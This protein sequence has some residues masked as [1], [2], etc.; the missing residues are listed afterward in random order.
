[1]REYLWLYQGKTIP[2]TEQAITTALEER[3][4]RAACPWNDA[5]SRA[6]T[7]EEVLLDERIT[8][9]GILLEAELL[10]EAGGRNTRLPAK[11]EYE[12]ALRVAEKEELVQI[13]FAAFGE[14]EFWGRSRNG[15]R[16]NEENLC[17]GNVRGSG[18]AI[19][20]D[21]DARMPKAIWKDFCVDAYI[22]GRYSEFL[23]ER[24]LFE[25]VLE[26]VLEEGLT[27][28]S[29]GTA[30]QFLEDMIAHREQYFYYFDATQP[31]LV[32]RGASC[33][34]NILNIFAEKLAEALEKL[35][36]RIEFYDTEAEDVQGLAR[37]LGKRYKASVGFQ[38]WILSA[39]LKG[40]K[41][42]LMNR[43]GG[44]K[45][46]FIFDHP[47]WMQEQLRHVPERY[48]VLTHDRNYTAF[49]R[50]YDTGVKGAYLLPPGGREPEGAEGRAE[51]RVRRIYDVAFLGTYGNY[52]EKLAVIADCVPEVKFLAARFLLYMKQ[53]P[54]STAEDAFQRA[55][56][57][58]KIRLSQE[59]FLELFGDLKAVIQCIMYYYREKAVEQIL[60]AGIELHVFGDSW[61][62]S[63][64]AGN[65][66]MKMHE[67]VYGEDA[68]RVL[69]QSKISLNI[70]AWHKD[71]FT[72]R[73]AESMLAGAVV[74]SDYSTQLEEFY[75]KETVLFNLQ[76]LG[77]LPRLLTELLCDEDRRKS[78]AE[79]AERKAR[80][81][82]TWEVRAKE[83][84][85]I[86][87]EESRSR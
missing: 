32:Y 43:I 14:T 38:A 56:D 29:A 55:L 9:N 33:C 70:M 77:D 68:V 11:W 81:T 78:L 64:F 41:D 37:L 82:A 59:A 48:Y 30:G 65:P 61:K 85:E 31:I 27:A 34:Y 18:G 76:Q 42:S 35:G 5:D 47:I 7:M 45:Y 40:S 21:K 26:A 8:E 69:T 72:E 6:L 53:S 46:N 51:G 12:L 15:Q 84:L 23:R 66:F 36:N 52:R 17:E 49:V 60:K 79:A 67:A 44:P 87:E 2:V 71:G 83:L 4:I 54:N 50:K 16:E 73:I 86:I 63:P 3:G 58:Y 24:G 1:M 39:Q 75:G 25:A 22:A 80:M 13:P 57:Y 74:V 20:E 62:D 28:E 19:G 10:R